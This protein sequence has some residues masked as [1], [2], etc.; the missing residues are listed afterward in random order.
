LF[1]IEM[2]FL[3]KNTENSV[4]DV[5]LLRIKAIEKYTEFSTFYNNDSAFRNYEEQFS[6]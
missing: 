4:L 5:R 2:S 1:A 3:W 6:P